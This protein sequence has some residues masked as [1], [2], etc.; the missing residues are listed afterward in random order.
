MKSKTPDRSAPGAFGPKSSIG[1]PEDSFKRVSVNG[2]STS[3]ASPHGLCDRAAARGVAE[4][5]R[6]SPSRRPA[7]AEGR[8]AP[9]D[10]AAAVSSMACRSARRVSQPM[11]NRITIGTAMRQ[12]TCSRLPIHTPGYPCRRAGI[13]ARRDFYGQSPE[14][15]SV[16]GCG[17]R[18]PGFMTRVLAQCLGHRATASATS[19]H[20]F[21]RGSACR[22]GVSAGVGAGPA[23][24]GM[25]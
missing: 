7:C 11:V 18:R 25:L 23:A 21:R 8:W 12:T 20:C 16:V 14:P 2:V 17:L 3:V 6:V 13:A 1:G 5:L 15:G 10:A 4:R 22:T 24:E 19:G 9:H